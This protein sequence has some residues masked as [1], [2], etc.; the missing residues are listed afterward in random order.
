MKEYHKIQSVYMRDPE[1][2]HKTFI[3]GEYAMPEFGYLADLEWEWSEKVDGTN[4]RVMRTAGEAV[5]FGGKTDRASI[6]AKLVDRLRERFGAP[7]ALLPAFPDSVNVCLY[8]EGYGAGI[9]SGGAYRQDQDFVLFDILISD[10]DKCAL[11]CVT[12]NASTTLRDYASHATTASASLRPKRSP[13]STTQ[14]GDGRIPTTIDPFISGGDTGS[15]LTNTID[16][17]KAKG[18]PVPSAEGSTPDAAEAV[19]PCRSPLTTITPPE[20]SEDCFVPDVTS[21]STSVKQTLAGSVLPRCT[22]R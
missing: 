18:V 22:C 4:I 21:R 1:N 19:S 2:R 7:D 16:F 3:M 8:G 9:Q 10:R 5:S 20:E 15:V 13:V 12:P 6:P 14:N 11:H 17:S